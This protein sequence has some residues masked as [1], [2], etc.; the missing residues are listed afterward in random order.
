MDE[1]EKWKEYELEKA[2]LRELDLLYSEYERR[3]REIAERLGI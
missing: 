1:Q 3:L 2:K